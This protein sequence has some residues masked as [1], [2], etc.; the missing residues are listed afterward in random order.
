[1]VCPWQNNKVKRFLLSFYIFFSIVS[2]VNN[3]PFPC[4]EA[5]DGA[6]EAAIAATEADEQSRKKE[7]K[8][9]EKNENAITTSENPQVALFLT[10]R[11]R[12][13]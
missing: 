10:F 6:Y 3:K 2:L 1:M 12:K 11:R 9:G 4:E 5:D 7:G 13:W 8:E